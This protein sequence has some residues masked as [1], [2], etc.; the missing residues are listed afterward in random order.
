M[1]HI[2]Q[3][4][5]KLNFQ[6]LMLMR[7]CAIN[8]PMEALWRFN[9]TVDTLKLASELTMDEINEL[10]SCGRSVIVSLPANTPPHVSKGDH[11]ILISQEVNN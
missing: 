11:A 6:Y 5:E 10:S 8:R 7:E 4:L 3:D 9:L 2:D 1:D